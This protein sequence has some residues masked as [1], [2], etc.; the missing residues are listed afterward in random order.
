VP[1][2][3]PLE[4]LTEIAFA[5]ALVHHKL[6]FS[7]PATWFPGV[8]LDDNGGVRIHPFQ[9]DKLGGKNKGL[10]M[11]WAKLDEGYSSPDSSVAHRDNE[12]GIFQFMARGAVNKGL[13]RSVSE[14][15]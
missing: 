5:R 9:A 6:A 13:L 12:T 10:A 11:I 8:P 2:D 3:Y 1:L 7:A 14:A 4:S 15:I